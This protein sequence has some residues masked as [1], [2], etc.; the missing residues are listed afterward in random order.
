[1]RVATV[2]GHADD[3]RREL[4]DDDGS[5]AR[6]HGRALAFGEMKINARRHQGAGR[7]KLRVS[8]V[9]CAEVSERG[10]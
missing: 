7:D 9:S 3:A 6:A 1:M 2:R 5:S 4:A 8:G 10:C